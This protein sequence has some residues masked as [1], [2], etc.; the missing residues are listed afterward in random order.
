[1]E[2]ADTDNSFYKEKL[3]RRRD[4]LDAVI[5]KVGEAGGAAAECREAHGVASGPD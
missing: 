3:R 5:R 4:L 1:M 2:I